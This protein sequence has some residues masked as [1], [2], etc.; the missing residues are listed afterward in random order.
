VALKAP[1]VQHYI[2]VLGRVRYRE[3]GRSITYDKRSYELLDQ[4]YEKLKLI[5]PVNKDG[6]RE[7]W[8]CAERGTIDDFGTFEDWY[9]CGEVEDE[10]EFTELWQAYFPDDVEWYNFQAIDDKAINYRA[11]FVKNK[12]VIQI[13]E[14]MGGGME[15]DIS[16]FVQWLLDSVN[17]C[18]AMLKAGTYNDFVERNLTCQHKTGTIQRKHWWDH[19]TEQRK[20]LHEKLSDTE[21]AEF[22]AAMERQNDA[23]VGRRVHFTAGEF[24]ECCA[25]GYRAN[26]YAWC[27]LTPKEQYLKHADGRD[28]GLT[29]I[30]PDSSEAFRQWYK[31]RMRHGIGHPWEVCRGGDSTHVSLQVCLDEGGYYLLVA[32]DAWTRYIETV[33][34]YLVLRR[35][36]YPI[37]CVEGNALAERMLETE[38]VGIVPEGVFPAYCS[39]LFPNEHVIDFANLPEENREMLAQFCE[40]QPLDK[41]ALL[42]GGIDSEL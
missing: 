25:L 28:D 35:A 19:Y 42:D 16:E 38:R 8:F 27:D 15:Y 41:I 22:V 23:S 37:A 18:I 21:I 1:R 10:K 20:E 11:I 32:G 34:F 40:W 3:Y 2:D 9:E 4:L 17:D 7:L 14:R 33:K 31:D 30:D 6:V 5:S 26:D 12:F 13:D 24:F 29:T 36:G 39:I